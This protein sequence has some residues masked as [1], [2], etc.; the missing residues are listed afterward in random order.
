MQKW[1]NSHLLLEPDQSLFPPQ[2]KLVY[3]LLFDRW[4]ESPF[5]PKF[6][7]Q[8][9]K[10]EILLVRQV[11]SQD[12]NALDLACLYQCHDLKG[13]H[14]TLLEKN[15]RRECPDLNPKQCYQ[16]VAQRIKE[17]TAVYCTKDA[18]GFTPK[19]APRLYW[20][21]IRDIRWTDSVISQAFASEDVDYLLFP[22]TAISECLQ[23]RIFQYRY[24][25]SPNPYHSPFYVANTLINLNKDV[26][27]D[28][29]QGFV[30]ENPAAILAQY[31]ST[32][33]TNLP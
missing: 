25:W 19:D 22:F 16:Q 23:E 24:L 31:K 10:Q 29:Q 27:F 8:R 3:T 12:F 7:P 9:M 5:P 4:G 30:L 28:W 15:L 14:D 1:R 17:L 32:K 11:A 33:N 20:L 18:H 26:Q 21:A 6:S 13:P 2:A